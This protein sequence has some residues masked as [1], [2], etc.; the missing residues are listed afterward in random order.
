MMLELES[1]VRRSLYSP[2]TR[3]RVA[4]RERGVNYAPAVEALRDLDLLSEEFEAS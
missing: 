2:Q 4:L 3:L 1:L